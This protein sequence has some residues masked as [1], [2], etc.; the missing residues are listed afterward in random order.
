MPLLSNNQSSCDL[1]KK[2]DQDPITQ[3]QMA[4]LH[5]SRASRES[6]P[7]LNRLTMRILPRNIYE[8]VV[9]LTAQVLLKLDQ[10]LKGRPVFTRLDR[11]EISG[12]DPNFLG[13]FL[14]REGG[15]NPKLRD[16]RAEFRTVFA[17]NWL[18]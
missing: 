17:R 10:Y 15:S 12:T 3:R 9:L 4:H 14:L 6:L 8:E 16:I 13:E 18:L 5:I 7:P 2:G 11:L 1:T